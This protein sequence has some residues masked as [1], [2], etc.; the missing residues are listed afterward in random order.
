MV[1]WEL[2]T[3]GV[4]NFL[5]LGSR[6]APESNPAGQR[7]PSDCRVCVELGRI[8]VFDAKERQLVLT[9]TTGGQSANASTKLIIDWF[10]ATRNSPQ[11]DDRLRL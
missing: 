6:G 7:R 5:G 4:T 8:D 11:M 10:V 3:R 9:W 1:E 2:S